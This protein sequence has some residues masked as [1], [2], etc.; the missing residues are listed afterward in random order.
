LASDHESLH[1]LAA[2]SF[3]DPTERVESRPTPYRRRGLATREGLTTRP[4]AYRL[5]VVEMH[6]HGALSNFEQLEGVKNKV[7]TYAAIDAQL[8]RQAVRRS[9]WREERRDPRP[10]FTRKGAPILYAL[11]NVWL[12]AAWRSFLGR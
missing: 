8:Q 6:L 5:I 11:L 9:W 12:M 4:E 7:E 1:H 2:E 10:P 3:D